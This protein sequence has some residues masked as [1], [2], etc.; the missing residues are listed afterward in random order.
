MGIDKTL[1]NVNDSL[2]YLKFRKCPKNMYQ[3]YYYY[4]CEGCLYLVKYKGLFTFIEAYNPIEVVE[5][6]IR[7]FNEA[8]NKGE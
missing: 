4:Y 6:F 5:S 3:G 7:I 8:K 2:Y 1:H